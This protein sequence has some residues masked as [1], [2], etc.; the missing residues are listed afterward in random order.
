MSTRILTFRKEHWQLIQEIKSL[1]DFLQ[2]RIVQCG[3]WDRRRIMRDEWS[4][5]GTLAG[6]ALRHFVPATEPADPSS[7]DMSSTVSRLGVLEAYMA[8]IHEA[9]VS[10]EK[11]VIEADMAPSFFDYGTKLRYSELILPVVRNNIRF[12]RRLI[13]ILDRKL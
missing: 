13:R 7:G 6:G 8:K 4:Q 10:A 12:L 1:R 11:I 9:I 3:L 2:P 5:V